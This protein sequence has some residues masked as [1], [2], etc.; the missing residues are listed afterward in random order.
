MRTHSDRSTVPYESQFSVIVSPNPRPCPAPVCLATRIPTVGP[1]VGVAG[2]RVRPVGR[3]RVLCIRFTCVV[4]TCPGVLRSAV[5][6]MLEARRVARA[7]GARGVLGS[8]VAHC[9]LPRVAC[10]LRARI[11]V[12][13]V[14]E[15]CGR[16]HT[17][18]RR[19]GLGGRCA[20]LADVPGVPAGVAAA[21]P[22][23]CVGPTVGVAGPRVRPVGRRRVLCIRFTCVVATCPGVLRSAV[24][25]MLE[26]RRVARAVGARGV[27]GSRVVHC[28]LP[29]G[30][31]GGRVSIRRV[32]RSLPS[33]PTGRLLVSVSALR[34]PYSCL[35]KGAL[36]PPSSTPAR[37]YSAA[38]ACMVGSHVPPL[39]PPPTSSSS[40]PAP[41]APHR[42][43]RPPWGLRMARVCVWVGG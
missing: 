23:G 39:P 6:V 28:R 37:R 17:V 31:G 8:R 41:A 11:T 21:A 33:P 34:P 42:L 40:S 15:A 30:G 7:V 1:T 13:A 43:H 20:C 10:P 35:H 29:R 38:P 18:G 14:P 3:R 12:A 27:L 16:A 25:V 5:C 2:P 24:C 32:G 4:A 36:I 9:C 22:L 19:G 26:A